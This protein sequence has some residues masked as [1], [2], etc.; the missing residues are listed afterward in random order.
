MN[1]DQLTAQLIVDEGRRAKPYV[2]TVGK[3]TIGVGRNLTDRGLS[4]AEVDFLLAND[5]DLVQHELDIA[6]PWWT[7][8]SDARQ[9]VL[10]N[11][12]FNMS[13]PRLLEFKKML[14]AM[15]AG[16]WDAASDEMLD[17]TWSRQVGARAGRLAAQMRKGEF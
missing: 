17:S 3:V 13:V 6:L 14:A 2:D 12:A 16:R 8:L 15:L 5:I 1:R 4:L 9:N 10:A 11:M 7:M